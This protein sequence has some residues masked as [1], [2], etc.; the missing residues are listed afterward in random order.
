MGKICRRQFLGCSAAALGAAC[1]ACRR[2]DVYGGHDAA[3]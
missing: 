1:P 3:G 2:R